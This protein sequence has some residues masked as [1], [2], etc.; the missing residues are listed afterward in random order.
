MIS[1]KVVVD[2]D[3]NPEY[4]AA[5]LLAETLKTLLKPE[6]SVDVVCDIP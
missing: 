5:H 4:K 1:I 3:E 6:V 2:T